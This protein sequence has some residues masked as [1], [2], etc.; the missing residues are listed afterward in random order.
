MPTA[1]PITLRRDQHGNAPKAPS[2]VRSRETEEKIL[3][4]ARAIL[5]NEGASALSARKLAK[6]CG[7]TT[8]AIY[9]LFSGMPDIL[10]R[11]YED[12]LK[13]EIATVEDSFGQDTGD[14]TVDQLLQRFIDLDL[15]MQ[16]GSRFDLELEDAVRRTPDMQ[17]VLEQKNAI[18]RKPIAHSVRTRLPH[19]TK[20]QANAIAAYIV[21]LLSTAYTLRHRTKLGEKDLIYG[22]TL[23]MIRNLFM[24][25]TVDAYLSG[26]SAPGAHHPN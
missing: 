6:Q 18:L 22:L 24:R 5:Q 12:Q 8:G 20:S 7:I 11:L 10:F 25:A 14:G 13:Q 26:G 2:Q 21:S 1:Q 19:L 17:D 23:G 9:N 15:R 3:K 16:W 4:G